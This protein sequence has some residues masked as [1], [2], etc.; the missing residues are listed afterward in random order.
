MSEMDGS[1]RGG[2]ISNT[3][4]F[5]ASQPGKPKPSKD[6]ARAQRPWKLG[7]ERHPVWS[8]AMRLERRSRK[9][10]REVA[11]LKKPW[12]RQP[13]ERCHKRAEQ[14][15]Q[16]KETW[17]EVQGRKVMEKKGGARKFEYEKNGKKSTA[18]ESCKWTEAVDDEGTARGKKQGKGFIEREPSEQNVPGR[19]AKAPTAPNSYGGW[20]AAYEIGQDVSEIQFLEQNASRRRVK[21]VLHT[22][23]K[24]LEV[25]QH[26][27]TSFHRVVTLEEELRRLNA[28]GGDVDPN[29]AGGAEQIKAAARLDNAQSLLGAYRQMLTSEMLFEPPPDGV[30]PNTYETRLRV[31]GG[32][33][34][35]AGQPMLLPRLNDLDQRE[36]RRLF[37]LSQRLMVRLMVRSLWG[38]RHLAQQVKLRMA[39]EELEKA[40][41]KLKPAMFGADQ[42]RVDGLRL[43]LLHRLCDAY[44][45][46]FSGGKKRG[47]ADEQSPGW[48][49][50]ARMWDAVE[51]QPPEGDEDEL[52][53]GEQGAEEAEE[54]EEAEHEDQEAADGGGRTSGRR[55][56]AR[57]LDLSDMEVKLASRLAALL[58]ST[59]TSTDTPAEKQA[60]VARLVRAW[61]T[62]AG[63]NLATEGEEGNNPG[64]AAM[65]A[66]SRTGAAIE[67]PKG[68]AQSGEIEARREWA[69]WS[70]AQC[71][72]RAQSAREK[73]VTSAETL[74]AAEQVWLEFNEDLKYHEREDRACVHREGQAAETA[75]ANLHAA[76]EACARARRMRDGV[77]QAWRAAKEQSAQAEVTVREAKREAAEAVRPQPFSLTPH[78]LGRLGPRTVRRLTCAVVARVSLQSTRACRRWSS[79]RPRGTRAGDGGRWSASSRRDEATVVGWRRRCG[80]V[81]TA[82]AATAGRTRR[83]W[84]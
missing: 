15:W 78:G 19:P 64:L 37:H 59:N 65:A 38:M 77:E 73:V 18:W 20:D 30:D 45:R 63:A 34:A 6:H 32:P 79:G 70:L 50:F 31:F 60:K 54:A 13:S 75:A 47:T 76:Q 21:L 7:H 8:E 9:A 23:H 4:R 1:V 35:A 43:G 29:A 3:A 71:E 80:G 55:K 12:Q 67:P 53:Q 28:R 57:L 44:E 25:G 84:A 58:R 81:R 33:A 52:G 61:A 39:V 83:R 27:Q 72:K 74:A 48:R 46:M 26:S 42:R 68:S 69:V 41:V 51:S 11:A 49:L 22:L 10:A 66:D 16:D 36:L 2:R 14:P 40:R 17:K 5:D 56:V 82:R 24:M 62:H